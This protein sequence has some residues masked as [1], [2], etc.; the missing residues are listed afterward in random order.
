M[1]LLGGLF[2][3]KY[4]DDDVSLSRATCVLVQLWKIGHMLGNTQLK[5]VKSYDKLMS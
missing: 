2:S 5:D 3:S 1:R 4:R